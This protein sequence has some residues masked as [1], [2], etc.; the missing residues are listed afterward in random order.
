MLQKPLNALKTKNCQKMQHK[1]NNNNNNLIN[2]IFY[3]SLMCLIHTFYPLNE[4]QI[5]C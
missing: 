5:H 4:F 2:L 3:I 1:F